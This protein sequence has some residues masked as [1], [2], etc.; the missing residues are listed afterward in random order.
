M[1]SPLTVV[2]TRHEKNYVVIPNSIAQNKRLT[3]A[4]RGLLT[5]LL[6]LPDGYHVSVKSL[7][8]QLIEGQAAIN[9][10][11]NEL[12]AHG[13]ITQR[14]LNVNGRWQWEMTV[15]DTP[16]ADAATPE[17]IVGTPA[18]AEPAEEP[19]PTEEAPATVPEQPRHKAEAIT[20][21]PRRGNGHILE[22]TDKSTGGG[23]MRAPATDHPT[24]EPSPRGARPPDGDPGTPCRGCGQA[25]ERHRQ[26]VDAEAR[27]KYEAERAYSREW[28]DVHKAKKSPGRSR[29]DLAAAEFEAGKRQARNKYKTP[30]RR[31]SVTGPQC[32]RSTE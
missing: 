32:D 3:L 16:R 25:R 18:P 22:R 15:F 7:A 6:S 23:R 31:A 26:W 9:R 21:K 4:A 2:R 30:A 24:E 28:L 17:D 5:H 19:A 12:M 13:Y 1:S 8:D 14:R 27:R 20:R 11:K 10:M 29:R